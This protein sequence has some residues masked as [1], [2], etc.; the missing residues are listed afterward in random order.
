[1]KLSNLIEGP[2]E[3]MP[4]G[5]IDHIQGLSPAPLNDRLRLYR[6]LKSEPEEIA[7]AAI[8]LA[9]EASRYM[10][11]QTLLLDGGHFSAV[12]TMWTTITSYR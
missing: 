3:K 2:I 11:G 6:I 7:N 12:R 9:S 4:D 8:F 1:M 10:T 5:A